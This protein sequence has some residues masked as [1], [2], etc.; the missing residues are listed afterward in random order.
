MSAD[1]QPDD[2]YEEISLEDL[3]I[4]T[5]QFHYD[6]IETSGHPQY[7][8]EREWH[9]GC[10]KDTRHTYRLHTR[11]DA[12]DERSGLL[13]A[14]TDDGDITEVLLE[15]IESI[16]DAAYD[17][18]LTVQGEISQRGADHSFWTGTQDK[19]YLLVAADA[20]LE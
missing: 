2:E 11:A 8:G 20:E 16:D 3:I 1:E 17:G 14:D 13:V 4:D 9:T 10:C 12:G 7:L 15:E 19:T 18:E 6:D 5:E